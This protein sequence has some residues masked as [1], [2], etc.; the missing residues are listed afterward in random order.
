MWAL[1]ETAQDELVTL[2]RLLNTIEV[3]Q[4]VILVHDAAQHEAQSILNYQFVLEDHGL[5][6]A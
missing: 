6:L 1:Q 3:I 2:Q 5:S 4:Q